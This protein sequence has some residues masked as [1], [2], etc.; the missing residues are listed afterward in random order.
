MDETR[1]LPRRMAAL[2]ADIQNT[3]RGM[4]TTPDDFY[5]AM[6]PAAAAKLADELTDPAN[7]QQVTKIGEIAGLQRHDDWPW[8]TTPRSPAFGR[9]RRIRPRSAAPRRSACW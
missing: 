3:R 8:R 7:Q 1:D 9:S 6:H 2:A 5:R 4:V